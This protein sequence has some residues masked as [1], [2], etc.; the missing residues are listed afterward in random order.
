[1]FLSFLAFTPPLKLKPQK[2]RGKRACKKAAREEWKRGESFFPFL[3]LLPLFGKVPEVVVAAVA[4]KGEEAITI[5]SIQKSMD[6]VS[7]AHSSSWKKSFPS[8]DFAKVGRSVG[9]QFEGVSP[10]LTIVWRTKR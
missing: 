7:V 4:R 9:W 10:C 8:P 6:G 2:A 1:M 5:V 3:Q